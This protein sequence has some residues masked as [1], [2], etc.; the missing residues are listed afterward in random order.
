MSELEMFDRIEYAERYGLEAYE[1]MRNRKHRKKV[2]ND[3]EG[4]EED[5]P[6]ED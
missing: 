4:G 5:E 3:I 6:L 2:P 1:S